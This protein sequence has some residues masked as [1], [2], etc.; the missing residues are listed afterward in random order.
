MKYLSVVYWC[1]CFPW[2]F[3]VNGNVVYFFLASEFAKISILQTVRV[4]HATCHTLTNKDVN[5]LTSFTTQKC[6][7]IKYLLSFFVRR[8]I[9]N[10]TSP[11]LVYLY[12][13]FMWIVKSKVLVSSHQETYREQHALK[14]WSQ[15]FE[16]ENQRFFGRIAARWNVLHKRNEHFNGQFW[17]C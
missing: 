9:G 3:V 8:H 17:I 7:F 10:V 1:V 6:N 11:N 14:R 4:N 12:W 15:K 2:A 13:L 16:H 5:N